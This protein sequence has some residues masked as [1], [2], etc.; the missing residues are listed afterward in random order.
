MKNR[1]CFRHAAGKERGSNH[2]GRSVLEKERER[3]ILSTIEHA[4]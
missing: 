4:A 2:L 1:F 3:E